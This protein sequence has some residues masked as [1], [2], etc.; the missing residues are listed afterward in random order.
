MTAPLTAGRY[1]GQSVKRR[2]DPRLLTGRGRYVDDVQLPG[3]LHV[4]FVRS[5]IA[6]GRILSIDADAARVLPGVE[7]IYTGDDL[8]PLIKQNWQ[9]MLGPPI[10]MGG[11][12]LYPP[13]SV[14]ADGDVRYVGDPI[15]IVIATSRYIAE[16]AA[17]LVEVEI[18]AMT[19]LLDVYDAARP[20]AELVH[21]EFTTN[22][23]SAM[24]MPEIPLLEEAFAGA[25]HVVTST[26]RQARVT[27]V[28]ME[29]RGLVVHYDR[30]AGD[31]RIWAATQSA[32]EVKAY[33]ARIT[34]LSESRVRAIAN[35]V[36]GGFGQKMMVSRDESAVMLAG[37]LLGDA[38]VKWIEDR[39]EN[40]M[41]A[42]QARSEAAEVSMAFD[43]DGH[44]LGAKV[45]FVEEC[46]A[47]PT[48]AGATGPMAAG[49]FPGPYRMPIVAPASTATWTNTAPKL[50]YRGPWAMETIFRE[51]ML[52]HAAREI[53]IDPLE[54]RRRNVIHQ[55]ELP[56]T[57]CTTMVYDTMSPAETLDQAA[58]LIGAAG[59]RAEQSAARAQGRLLGLGMSLYVEP[60]AI[61]FGILSSDMAIMRM[62][63]TGKVQVAMSTGSHGHSLETTIPQIVAEHLGCDIEDVVLI[64]G[65]TDSAPMGPGTGGSRSAVVA[66]GAAQQASLQL[67]DKL[68]RIAAQLMEASPDDLEVANSVVSV[69]G[70]PQAAIPFAQLA[71]TAYM[72][73]DMLPPGMESGLEVKERYRPPTPFTWSNA[74]HACVVEV[75]AETGMVKI[76][77]YVVSEDCGTMINPMVV[78]GQIAGGVVQ[79]I[80]GVLFEHMAYDADGNPLA[81]TFLDYLIPTAPEVPDLVYGHIE[82]KAAG[83]GGYKGMGEGG[84]IGA[85]PAV[86]NAI[87]DA[88]AHLGASLTDFPMGPSQVLAAINAAAN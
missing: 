86:A 40:L 46:G 2:E 59:F 70:T 71:M 78:E 88:I 38:P 67:K 72:A 11:Q 61:S 52:D 29:T 47:F 9:T 31:M 84:A 34:G 8:N 66:G 36:G 51:Q 60:S 14:L 76:L 50:A 37:F 18:E 65:D 43:A 25:A 12:T 64:Q 57:T 35:D 56:F 1:V 82:T 28:P 74:S 83:V 33:A 85:P 32:S 26:F 45:H 19:P 10:E 68:I 48:G 4:A 23:T 24:P 77:R 44:I 75:D 54:L 13:S 30:F 22:V 55:S 6:R 79:G 41:C 81:T 17:E 27:N 53:G 58:E 73:P 16:D 42:N 15:A 49:I 69:K 7:A 20:D 63:T 21:P 5:N 62:D 39:R 3:M 80:G 87:N